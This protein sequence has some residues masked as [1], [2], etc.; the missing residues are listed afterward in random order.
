MPK[1]VDHDR[2]RAEIARVTMR[3]IQKVGL[4]KTTIRTIAR[5]GGFT[6]GVLSHYF[7]DKDDIISFAFQ[8]VADRD[9]AEIESAAAGLSPGLPRLRV[10]LDRM[11]LDP[12]APEGAAV[13]LSFWSAAVGNPR[14]VVGYQENYSRWRSYV[15]RY[16]R[17][18]LRE[19]Q[20]PGSVVIDDAVDLLV[21]AVDGLCVAMILDPSRF[22][23]RRRRA[24]IERLLVGVTESASTAVSRPVNLSA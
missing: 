18:A 7:R 5:E 15:K 1:I 6:T 14:L 12:E 19:G 3:V 4:E 16:L 9:F 23:K 8:W 10:S 20:V 24:L 11:L 2:R 21:S 13:S 22:P 17:E